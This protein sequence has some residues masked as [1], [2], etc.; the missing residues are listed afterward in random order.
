MIINSLPL[1]REDKAYLKRLL[2]G[3]HNATKS[4]MLRLYGET[5]ET[6]Y[7]AT[8]CEISRENK[9][10][11]AA[12]TRIRKAMTEGIEIK[13]IPDKCCDNCEHIGANN[14][15]AKYQQQ[16]PDE[17]LQTETQCED[18]IYGIPF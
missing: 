14:V 6:V 9:A 1:S 18:F 8:D 16:V 7:N 10:R 5:W 17:Y 2:L 15:C 11:F 12:N 13:Q 3:H 4:F